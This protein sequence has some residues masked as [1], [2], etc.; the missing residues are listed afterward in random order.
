M[1]SLFHVGGGG[2][3]YRSDGSGL[4]LKLDDFGNVN[5]FYGGV[6]MGQGMHSV[7]VLGI[8]ES[9]GVSPEKVFINQTDTGTCPWD[10]GTHASRGAFMACNAVI[11]ATKNQ[12]HSLIEK[13]K[14]RG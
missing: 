6:E 9:L 11:K 10:V 5:V 13:N 2:R 12:G 14:G 7:L 3:I 1:A 4:I 8:A